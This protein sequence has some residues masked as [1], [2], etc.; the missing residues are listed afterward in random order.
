MIFCYIPRSSSYSA[1][2]R[3]A[4]TAVDW[5]KYRNTQPEIMQRK[6]ESGGGDGRGKERER[7]THTFWNTEP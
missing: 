1:I 3:E 2:I 6:R 4:P 7:E 5:N